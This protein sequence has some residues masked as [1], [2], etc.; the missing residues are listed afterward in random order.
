MKKKHVKIFAGG[1]TEGLTKKIAKGLQM[2]TSE[3]TV[4]RFSDG[5]FSPFFNESIRGDDVFLV[6]STPPPTDNFFELVLLIDAAKRASAHSIIAVIPYFGF[7]RQDRKDR[8]RTAITA[9]VMANILQNAGVNRVITMDLHAAQIQGF[10]DIPVDH[11]MASA[12]FAPYIKKMKIPNLTFAS[13]DTG[14]ADRVRKY[15]GHFDAD[16]VICDKARKRPNEVGSITVIGE[17]KGR[18]VII[19]DDLA[20]TAGTLCK[21]AEAIMEKGAKSVRAFCTHPVLSGKA[22]E[23]IE[24]SSLLKLVVTDTIPLRQKSKK[25]K[26]LSTA[27]LFATAIERVYTNKSVNGLFVF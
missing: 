20:D 21:T 9:K 10:F 2:K 7:A 18:N 5:E 4:R 24:N 27:P 22:Y 8:P 15:A 26:V 17:V 19:I 6:Q 11:L 16:F 1:V 3:I 25:I 14:S 12:I 23:N 13:P